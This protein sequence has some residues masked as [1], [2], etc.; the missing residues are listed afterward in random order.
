MDPRNPRHHVENRQFLAAPKTPR[1]VK[2]QQFSTASAL[3][4][5]SKWT[6]EIP[7][8]TSKTAN[9]LVRQKRREA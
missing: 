3:F 4:S 5:T 1:R 8:I 7:D 2:N 9:S 6:P